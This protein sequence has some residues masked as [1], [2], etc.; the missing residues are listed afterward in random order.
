MNI[1]GVLTIRTINGSN[2]PFN[3]G[4][5]IT[6]LGEFSVKDTLLEQYEEGRYEGNFNITQIFP[7]SYFA[8]GRFVVEVRATLKSL[9]LDGVDDLK[10]E[11]TAVASEPDP[12]DDHPAPAKTAEKSEQPAEAKPE[13]EAVTE[14][15]ES[16][17][18]LFG[19]L[20]PLGTQVKLDPTVDRL[21][22][23]LQ[24]N[25]LKDLGYTFDPREQ[26]WSKAT[27]H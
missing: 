12:A 25:R 21:K 14:E 9:S 13:S 11:D 2:G 6:D 7:S 10:P 1:D 3:V 22:F 8:G 18:S 16:D 19:T 20:W 27:T 26:I 17:E 5:L 15:D 4:R 24:R 23:R